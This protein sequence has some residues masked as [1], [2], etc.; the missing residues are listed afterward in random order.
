M[1]AARTAAMKTRIRTARAAHRIASRMIAATTIASF[2]TNSSSS[3][4]CATSRGWNAMD[5][6]SAEVLPD[7]SLDLS[8][9][10]RPDHPPALHTVSEENEQGNAVHAERRRDLWVLVDIELGE[11]DVAPLGR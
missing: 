11:A 7:R 5:G 2:R 1:P 3:L 8:F 9:R 6:F 10:N 4:R